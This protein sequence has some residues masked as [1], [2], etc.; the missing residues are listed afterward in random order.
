[1][2]GPKTLIA[3][4]RAGAAPGLAEAL[5]ARGVPVHVTRNMADTWLAV[6]NTAPEAVIV[7]PLSTDVDSVEFCSLMR[8]SGAPQGPA[9]LV[10]TDGPEFLEPRASAVDDYLPTAVDGEAALGRL[11]F[12]VARRAELSRLREEREQLRRQSM[13]DFKTGLFND[14]CFAERSREE[15]SRARRQGQPL[16]V[17]MLDLDAFKAINDVHGHAFGDHSLRT[18]ALHLRRNL[19]NFDISARMG[20]DEFAVLLPGTRVR[21]ALLV[22]ERIHTSLSGLN[23]EF[24]ERHAVLSVS[25]GV[26]AWSPQ[27][28]AVFD[29]TL[30]DADTALL[31]AKQQGRGRIAICEDG[32]SRLHAEAGAAEAGG[33]AAASATAS[34]GK[35]PAKTPAKAPSVL[36]APSAI[37]PAPAAGLPFPPLASPAAAATTNGARPAPGVKPVAPPSLPGAASRSPPPPAGSRGDTRGRPRRGRSGS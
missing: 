22:A 35:G 24:D 18:F 21:D 34:A 2:S 1:M 33:T 25:M 19:R 29:H 14:R 30:R 16:G 15:V 13:T 5:A 17:V 6:R 20:G 9:V 7:A 10:L 4:H 8:L 26:A 12:A 32:V 3:L 37:R 31:L 28:D 23:I 27:G 36:A 11:R